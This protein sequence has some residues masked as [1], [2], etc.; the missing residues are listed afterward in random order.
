MVAGNTAFALDLLGSLMGQGTGGENRN[1]VLSPYS[2]SCALAMTYAGAVGQTEEEMAR[3][4]RFALPPDR[5]HAAFNTLDQALAARNRDFPPV[6]GG[7]GPTRLELSTVN[8]LWAQAG[9]PFLPAFLDLLAAH[10]SAGL[11]LVD[12]EQDAPGAR[13][14]INAWVEEVTGDRIRDLLPEGAVG[15]L[16]RMVLTNAVYLKAPWATPFDKGVTVEGEF[17]LADG[18]IVDVLFMHQSETLGYAEGN[19]WQ[20]VE[21]PCQGGELRMLVLLPDDLTG[22]ISTLDTAAL[23]SVVAALQQKVVNLSLPRFRV[24]GRLAL[25]EALLSLGMRV[26]FSQSADFSGMTGNQDL[27]IDSIHHS[28]FVAVDEAG[29]EAAA[30]TAVVMRLRAA[31]M[32]P[33][34]VNVDRPFLWLIRDVET[35]TILF[36][37]QVADPSAGM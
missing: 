15:A 26:P 25:K 33:Q 17:H 9:Y 10:Y 12:F 7:D 8:Q 35:G 27:F 4:L 13:Q 32:D 21:I 29:T 24:E 18:S 1:I 30:A 37:G 11:R 14:A 6:A 16:T 36:L 28:G 22:F 5:L 23:D 34:I 31:P 2:I 20:A 3:V 19:G